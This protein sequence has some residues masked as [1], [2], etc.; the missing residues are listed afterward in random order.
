MWNIFPLHPYKKD[1]SLS[2]RKPVKKDFLLAQEVIDYF[3]NTFKFDKIYAIG[4]VAENKLKQMGLNPMY[5]RHP[6]YGGSSEF[7]ETMFSE[8]GTKKISLVEYYAK[9][10]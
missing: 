10:I 4:R 7:K 5:V 8:F 3:F 9:R 2:N 6:S 1:N